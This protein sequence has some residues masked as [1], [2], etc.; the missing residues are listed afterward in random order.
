MKHFIQCGLVVASV[1]TVTTGLTSCI[2]DDYDLSDID[3]TTE[4]KVNDLTVP[5]NFKDI[6]L[7]KIIDLDDS[8]PDAI[9]KVR[10]VN[11][12]KYYFINKGGDFNAD[13]KNI[14]KVH[15]PKPSYNENTSVRISSVNAAGSRRRAAGLPDYREYSVIMHAN[16]FVYHVGSDGN[17]KVDEAIKEIADV[18]LDPSEPLTV[19]LSIHSRDVASISSH[20]ELYD[21]ELVMP[22]GVT[23]RCGDIQSKNGRIVIPHLESQTGSISTTVVISALDFTSPQNPD[24]KKVRDGKF[25][26]EESIAIGSGRFLVYPKP[27]VAI[28]S[29]PSTIDFT[30]HYDL[31]P[32]TVSM[33][34]G[35]FD[36]TVDMEE[37]APIEFSDLPDFLLG[38]ET[39]IRLSEVA[40]GLQVNNPL[41]KYGVGC[42]AG[43][44]L[45]AQ[46]AGGSV[47]NQ[48]LQRFNISSA[49]ENQY[50]VL[51]TAENTADLF[52]IPQ[53]FL[54]IF[55]PFPGLGNMLSGAGLPERL[56]VHFESASTPAPKVGGKCH[57]FPLGVSIPQVHGE[58]SF[59]APL[60]L[61]DGSTIV[62]NHT[63]SGWNDEDVDAIAISKLTIRCKLTSTIPAAAKITVRPIDVL[64]NRIPLTN[65]DEAFAVL[66]ANAKDQ[67][68]TLELLGDIRH[69][70]GI[71]IE[72]MANGFDGTRLSPDQTIK[73]A[74]LKATVTGSYTKEL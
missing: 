41:A 3:T 43:L 16:D 47:D 34:S 22:E 18:T 71:Y 48:T 61:A 52:A 29:L 31:T 69:L 51:G 53:G 38:E 15:A 68:V 2:D 60:A 49:Q 40:I 39:D 6:Y 10:E 46:R 23:A 65:A 30:T 24:G 45:G 4:L 33:F 13:P 54:K 27:G 67:E 11:G 37:I 25:D 73:V 64:G 19:T 12:E 59:T 70:D 21:L 7:E 1:L 50:L 14:D 58:Y 17:P 26:I 57:N 9:I 32:F 44:T 5:V 42:S 56:L 63:N 8:D 72:A 66:P 20:V 55:E 36:Y 35:T 62:Y 28:S 74:D